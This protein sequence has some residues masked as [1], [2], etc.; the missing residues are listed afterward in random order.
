MRSVTCS[1]EVPHTKQRT[2]S[3]ASLGVLVFEP[4]PKAFA[5]AVDE[6]VSKEFVESEE[7]ESVNGAEAILR[8][9]ALG[10]IGECFV[11]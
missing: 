11:D 4:E 10:V 2:S 5:F 8:E 7:S 3:F 9:L 6:E 1:S